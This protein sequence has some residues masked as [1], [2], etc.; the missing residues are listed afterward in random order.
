[1]AAKTERRVMDYNVRPKVAF[2]S[3]TC[4]EGCQL[5]VLSCESE[6]PEILRHVNIVNFREAMTGKGDD[7]EVAFVEGSVSRT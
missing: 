6:L 2:F 4:C 3:F 7:Y 1:M 5:M